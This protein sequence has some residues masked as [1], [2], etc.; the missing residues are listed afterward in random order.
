MHRG[1][2]DGFFR[3]ARGRGGPTFMV[4]GT[5]DPPKDFKTLTKY[6]FFILY[7]YVGPCKNYKLTPK[8]PILLNYC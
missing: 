4:G 2:V 6:I 7:S 8:N 5:L 1:L 3:N